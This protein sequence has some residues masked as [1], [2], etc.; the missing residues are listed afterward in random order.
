MNQK[1]SSVIILVVAIAVVAIVIASAVSFYVLKSQ[2]KAPTYMPL[3]NDYSPTSNYSSP[4][5]S[6]VSQKD[7]INTLETE[8]DSTTT[9]EIDSDINNL[10]SS[11]SSL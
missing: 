1:G 10:N 3:N 2:G 4:T 6:S 11:A 8:L 9:G 5:P 7:D